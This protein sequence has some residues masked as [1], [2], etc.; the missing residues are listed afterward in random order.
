VTAGR[1]PRGGLCTTPNHPGFS[2]DAPALTGDAAP[3][4]K[5]DQSIVR[6]MEVIAM[7]MNDS[8]VWWGIGILVVVLLVIAWWAG[9]FGGGTPTATTTAPT[10]PAATTPATPAPTTPATPAR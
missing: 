2:V 5:K 3:V 4:P 10:P 7:D 1:S 6:N 8:R 9:W